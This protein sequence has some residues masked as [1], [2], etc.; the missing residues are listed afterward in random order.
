MYKYEAGRHE[1][2]MYK[3]EAEILEKK[4]TKYRWVVCYEK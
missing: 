1:K 4:Y 2:K 3:Y